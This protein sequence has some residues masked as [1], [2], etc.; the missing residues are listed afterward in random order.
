M[1]KPVK[2]KYRRMMNELEYLYEEYELLDDIVKHAAGEFE[3]YYR[4]FCARNNIDL[5]KLNDDNKDRI[6]DL[7]GVE[8]E[9]V[10]ETPITEYTGSAAMVKVDKPESEPLFEETEE[11]L[12]TFKKLHEYF[13]KL[14]KKVAMQLHPDRIEN[15]TASDEYKKKMA[16]DFSEA[17]S[18]LDKKNYFKLIKVAKKYNIYVTE[19]FTLQLKWFKKERDALMDAISKVKTTYNYKFS[20]CETSEEKDAVIKQFMWHLFRFRLDS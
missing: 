11:D 17:K 4:E 16:W 1:A 19:N 10:K 6:S 20:E 15:Y 8:P 12:G 5:N 7:Y 13:N 2:I 14:F 18:A 3:A 9:Q